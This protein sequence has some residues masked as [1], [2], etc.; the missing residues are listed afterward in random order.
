MAT[1]FRSLLAAT[2]VTLLIAT[3]PGPPAQSPPSS[4]NPLL[5]FTQ[6]THDAWQRAEGLPQNSVVA[7]AQTRDGYLWLGTFGGLVRFDGVRFT[8]FNS[9]NTPQ[10]KSNRITALLEDRDG[11]L[12]IGAESCELM[13]Y[14]LEPTRL[15]QFGLPVDE[16]HHDGLSRRMLN[17]ATDVKPRPGLFDVPPGYR[18]ISLKEMRG[19]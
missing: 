18:Q 17:S 10:L 15:Y 12:W 2:G 3:P 14:V 8:I 6:Y 5:P 16:V 19:G 1:I 7:M 4:L 13:R 9:A 11:A